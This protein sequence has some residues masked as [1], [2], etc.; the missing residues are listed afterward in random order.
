MQKRQ[1]LRRQIGSLALALLVCVGVMLG[2]YALAN[3]L[4]RNVLLGAL[5]GL[6]LAL[7][8][9]VILSVTVSNAIDRAARDG[10]SKRAKLEI[11]SS[12]LLRP[13]V[14]LAIYVALFRTN[15]C[16]PVAALLPLLFAQI[17]IKVL[18]FFRKDEPKGGDSNP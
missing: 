11:Q 9:F 7:G 16:D 8:N 4:T 10:E 14:L 3:A 13:I 12:A 2:F 17:A 6:A 18:E 5:I 1:E 15:I